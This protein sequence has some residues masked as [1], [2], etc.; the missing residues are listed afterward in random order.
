MS[1]AVVSKSFTIPVLHVDARV[2]SCVMLVVFFWMEKQVIIFQFHSFVGHNPQAPLSA[3]PVFQA[4]F[5]L[6]VSHSATHSFPCPMSCLRNCFS[7][8]FIFIFY[9][10]SFYSRAIF[11][12]HCQAFIWK[13]NSCGLCSC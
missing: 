12:S 3:V 13:R 8:C 6:T 5:L 10:S 2:L 1:L 11:V 4:L 9:W 7:F